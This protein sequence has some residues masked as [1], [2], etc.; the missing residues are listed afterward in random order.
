MSKFEGLKVSEIKKVIRYA[1]EKYGKGTYKV[2]S[3]FYKGTGIS[4][5]AWVDCDVVSDAGDVYS[6]MLLVC[7]S[8]RRRSACLNA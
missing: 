4:G 1:G 5:F 2:A 3:Y 6:V 7:M 8:D